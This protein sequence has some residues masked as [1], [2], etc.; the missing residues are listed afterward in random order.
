MSDD[1]C[2]E[3][4]FVASAEPQGRSWTPQRLNIRRL[5]KTRAPPLV[6][7]YEAAV[8]MLNDV[9][10][11]ARRMLIA[12]CVRELANSLPWY[13]EGAEGGQVSYSVLDVI[14]KP[15]QDAGLPL[16]EQPLP[17]AIG[18]SSREA[19]ES[20][21]VPGTI[22]QKVGKLL[23][24]HK[25]GKA[26]V[27]RN[28]ELIFRELDP[29]GGPQSIYQSPTLELWLKTRGW[30][31]EHV[32]DKH[33]STDKSN[34]S[35]DDELLSMFEQ[36]ERVLAALVQPFLE[37]ARSLDEDLKETN[38]K[39]TPEQIT[40]VIGKLARPGAQRYFFVGLKNPEWIEPLQQRGYFDNVPGVMPDTDKGTFQIPDWPEGQYL[41]RMADQKPELVAKVVA[42]A[43]DTD[44][45]RVRETMVDIA[46]RLPTDLAVDISR[47][48][49]KWDR[50]PI[51][52]FTLPLQLS[53]LV[54]HLAAG[55]QIKE[56]FKLASMV[57]SIRGQSSAN[58]HEP[59][60]GARETGKRRWQVM[61]LWEYGEGLKACLPSLVDA[62]PLR[63]VSF[64]G[65]LVT[66]ALFD[67]GLV[68]R[69]K[70]A[71]DVSYHRSQ[72]LTP[73]E[74]PVYEIESLLIVKLAEIAAHLIQSGKVGASEVIA[75]I[76]AKPWWIFRAISLH[77]LAQ[78]APL[79]ETLAKAR[80]LDRKLF[81]DGGSRGHY[82]HLLQKRFG[83]L[84]DAEQSQITGWIV[85][86]P[87]LDAVG[88]QY[89]AMY[90]KPLSADDLELH[91][92]YWIRD[93]LLWLGDHLPAGLQDTLRSLVDAIGLPAQAI[94]AEGI[95]WWAP[96][97]PKSDAEF[98]AMSPSDVVAFLR[99][100]S[101]GESTDEP[102]P[103]GVGYQL[104][105]AA[106]E[107]PGEFAAAADE[108]IGLPPTY[109]HSLLRGLEQ[110]EREDTEFDWLP[111]LSLC[112]WIVQQPRR[113][114]PE[115]PLV[116]KREDVTWEG[117][118]EAV[119]RLIADG[120]DKRL[121]PID[122]QQQVWSIIE[123]LAEDPDPSQSDEERDG[124]QLQPLDRSMN[125]V[126]G[127]AIRSA[128][129]YMHWQ[130]QIMD[131]AGEVPSSAIEAAR[132]LLERHLDTDI[133]P[134][135]AVRAVYG[136]NF[137]LLTYLD[138][139]WAKCITERIFPSGNGLRRWWWAAWSTY[140]Q[141]TAAYDNVF[142]LL[143][144]HY[145]LA[146]ER[147][148]EGLATDNRDHT[149]EHLG[150]HLIVFYWRGLLSLEPHDLLWKYM[151]RATPDLRAAAIAFVGRSLLNSPGDVPT[152][153][154]GRLRALWDAR[155][156][157]AVESQ[158]N[159]LFEKELGG[160]SFWFSSG[161]FDDDWAIRQLK[162]VIKLVGVEPVQAFTVIKRL[163]LIAPGMP[164]AAIECLEL[165][166]SAPAKSGFYF[167]GMQ[168]VRDILEAARSSGDVEVINKARR[169]ASLL[170]EH[171]DL[172]HRDIF[173][174]G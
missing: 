103:E 47:R 88:A 172:T 86:G 129:K 66:N 160:F 14:H 107:R 76:E 6:D 46:L 37:I 155:M 49:R 98:N 116:L 43:A 32:H 110:A 4:V 173:D 112:A 57:F 142:A 9:T 100:W 122:A 166:V 125:S 28:A 152:S 157:A 51:S 111:V 56:A 38:K 147:L 91:R 19:P 127:Q 101:P 115:Q 41:A 69:G 61:D 23:D 3:R 118:K 29:V 20:V 156:L 2:S 60:K 62:D 8:I 104:Q 171:G 10:F 106:K 109:V 81:D 149:A 92:K 67:S 21:Q 108:L 50:P 26:K 126:R 99:S 44:N 114:E 164:A 143:R 78:V 64:L 79:G 48:A 16:G 18:D 159:S 121:L 87:D 96:K 163:A 30:F 63:T 40:G 39:P 140:V 70:G 73:T 162:E 13:F 135:L 145:A 97:S 27:R 165:I 134:S 24:D 150:T 85:A 130:R 167:H 77:V 55:S 139:T 170:A 5:L 22:V 105:V 128:V 154:L 82:A 158:N 123:V 117:T 84:T 148:D 89:E 75:L 54:S 132:T 151:Q 45:V 58:G 174:L 119:A 53:K 124:D 1:I 33:R 95:S 131:N 12:H 31:M 35:T 15:W 102:S 65:E 36:F 141:F 120:L 7:L 72:N 71:F 59:A 74:S 136:Q 113:D 25:K 161:K 52:L 168:E 138:A 83:E 94:A 42:A 153:I 93:R 11:P 137:A 68:K 169:V 144:D 90:S 146:I 80:M 17:M 34:E 133:E